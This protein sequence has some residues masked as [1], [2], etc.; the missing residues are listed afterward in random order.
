ML[1]MVEV[2][3]MIELHANKK[4]TLLENIKHLK[5]VFLKSM[6]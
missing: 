5:I 6:M 2:G 4:Q 3:E 1:N